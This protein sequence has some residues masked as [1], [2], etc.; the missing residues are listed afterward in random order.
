MAY[1]QNENA[2]GLDALTSLESGDLFI[3]GDVSDSNRAK[4]ITKTNL[5]TDFADETQAFN[6]KTI[7]ADSNTI[8]NIDNADIK[9]AAAIALNKLAATTVSR[10][11]VSDGSGFVTAATTT[12]TEIGYVNGVTSAIQTQ[13][14]GKQATLSTITS[15]I[16]YPLTPPTGETRIDISNNTTAYFS[17]FILSGPM[18]VGKITFGLSANT[19]SGSTTFDI[20]IYSQD[21]QTQ[22]ISVT[23]GSITMD[24]EKSVSVTVSPAV[25]L[26]PGIYYVGIVPN[27][28]VTS[29]IITWQ[30]AF[31]GY[32]FAY[33]DVVSGEPKYYG[34]K[35]V[36]AGTLPTTINP[37]TDLTISGGDEA[38]IIRLDN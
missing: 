21:G 17:S 9:A 3:V 24:T 6:N 29:G 23:S 12:A 15:I 33:L 16:P 19:F 28:S 18:S 13:L 31:D 8:T 32:K 1:T 26:Q 38:P 36:T 11:L 22:L 10:A 35:T 7:D 25:V 27:S 2:G 5:L 14:N 20:V 37:I 34:S 30:M 4:K